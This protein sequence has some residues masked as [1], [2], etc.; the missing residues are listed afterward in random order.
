MPPFTLKVIVYVLGIQY[1]VKLKSSVNSNLDINQEIKKK[2]KV[3]NKMSNFEDEEDE[4]FPIKSSKQNN[5]KE[6]KKNYF[7]QE[8]FKNSDI[9]AIPDASFTT[10]VCIE[11]ITLSSRLPFLISP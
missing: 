2:Q 11:K 3:Y 6:E 10:K 1:A 9:G 4:L 5:S 8:L 7:L